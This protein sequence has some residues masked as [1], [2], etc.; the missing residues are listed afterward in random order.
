MNS[1]IVLFL[2]VSRRKTSLFLA[3]IYISIIFLCGLNMIAIEIKQSIGF[4]RSIR[5]LK[6]QIDDELKFLFTTVRKKMESR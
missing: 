2:I 5:K 3:S 1:T 6:S 4:F